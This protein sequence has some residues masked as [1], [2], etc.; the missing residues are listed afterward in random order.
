[1]RPQP[2]LLCPILTLIPLTVLAG[3]T[4]LTTDF[5][6]DWRPDW[7]PD[8]SL[9]AFDSR[10]SNP[11]DGDIWVIPV[12]GGAPTQLTADPD[13]D[14]QPAWSP[15]GTEIAFS[16]ERS[17]NWDIWIIETSTVVVEPAT[18]GRIKMHFR[19]ASSCW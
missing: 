12:S 11:G 5:A 10:R 16:S 8:G 6:R 2:S 18:W 19:C 9:I 4:Q 3:P 15:D 17:G 7:S 1:M 13:W 14:T